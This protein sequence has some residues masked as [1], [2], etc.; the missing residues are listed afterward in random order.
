MCYK[1]FFNLAKFDMRYGGVK[2][3]DLML[4]AFTDIDEKRGGGREDDGKG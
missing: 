4:G 2:S 3:L 1:Y